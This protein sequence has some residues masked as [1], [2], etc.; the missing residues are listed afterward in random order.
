MPAR[1]GRRRGRRCSRSA[2][3][4]ASWPPTA[5]RSRRSRRGARWRSDRSGAPGSPPAKERGWRLEPVRQPVV[6]AAARRFGR[7]RAVDRRAAGRLPQRCP[8]PVRSRRRGLRADRARVAAAGMDHPRRTRAA[9]RRGAPARRRR[10][11]AAAVRDPV[12]GQGQHRRRRNADDR[13]LS[14][15][16]ARRRAHRAGRA[17]ADRRRRVLVGKTNMDQFATGLVGTRSPTARAVGVRSRSRQRRLELRARR[18][19][20]RSASR[21]S[22][23]APTPPARVASRRHSTGSSGS[24]RRGVCSAPAAWCPRARVSTA[25]R[26][27]PPASPTPR[28][29]STSSPRP[30]R[31]TRGAGSARRA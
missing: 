24:S 4:S 6:A 28:R 17:A 5:T 11:R 3:T 25:S 15:V 12:R 22:R 18:S 27:S 29:C 2:R 20:W 13:R 23:S 7:R 16:R 19:P 9:A 31:S 10:P 26:F 21:R 1:G 30:T 14:G 8:L